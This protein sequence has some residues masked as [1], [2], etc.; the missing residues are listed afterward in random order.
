MKNPNAN[1]LIQGM[2]GNINLDSSESLARA[3]HEF[4]K[5][6]ALLARLVASQDEI[7]TEITE[8]MPKEFY[9]VKD[10]NLNIKIKVYEK[11]SPLKIFITN[12]GQK[13]KPGGT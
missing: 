1:E 4:T 13:V 10:I 8:K 9:M 2:Q 3:I 11:I 7:I 5:I 6:K 12:P